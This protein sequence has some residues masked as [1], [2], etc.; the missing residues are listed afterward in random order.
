[1]RNAEW[2]VRNGVQG[3]RIPHSE[4]HMQGLS[5]FKRRFAI[6]G[7]YEIAGGSKPKEADSSPGD[8]HQRR[9]PLPVIA[10]MVQS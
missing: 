5:V 1:M 6:V 8:R 3:F 7:P 4:F 9:V 2:G 10:Y